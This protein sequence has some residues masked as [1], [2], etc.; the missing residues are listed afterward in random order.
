MTQHQKEVQDIANKVVHLI[1]KDTTVRARFTKRID[2]LCKMVEKY[3]QA[4]QPYQEKLLKQLKEQPPAKFSPE[5]TELKARLSQPGG[6]EMSKGERDALLREMK[7]NE[8]LPPDGWIKTDYL[9]NAFVNV[10]MGVIYRPL[11]PVNPLLWFGIFG[12]ASIQRKPTE[13]ETLMCEYVR[14]AIIHDF[15]L[16]YSWTPT[17]TPLF[18]D[19][20][21]GKWFQRNEFCDDVGA[22]YYYD[23]QNADLL[24]HTATVHEK[25]SHLGHA[26]DKV[27][28]D[29]ANLK[30][31]EARGN[32]TPATIINI[33]KLNVLRDVQAENMQTGDYSSIQKQPTAVEKK[34]SIVGKILKIIVKV[35]G[36]IIVG[37]I[38]AV[39]IDIL[40]DFGWLQSIKEL[41]YNGLPK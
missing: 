8:L 10:D 17:D 7:Q 27:Q 5:V 40:G 11:E 30:P 15:V 41:I 33:D 23:N 22:Y 1:I 28:A 35:I 25:L 29:I 34:K 21:N 32:A 39:V 19:K 16:R 18:S 4:L 14:L 37:I 38:V 31:E 6:C 2:R 36:A 12:D 26:F 24:H 20:Y 3:G 9:N 13:N